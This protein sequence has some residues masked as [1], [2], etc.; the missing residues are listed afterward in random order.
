LKEKKDKLLIS[1][2]FF[3][4]DFTYFVTKFWI[5]RSHQVRIEGSLSN[6]KSENR[7]VIKTNK[8]GQ[9]GYPSHYPNLAVFIFFL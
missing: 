1:E 3:L 8:P 7:R 5:K 6:K 2:T 9:A 4:L